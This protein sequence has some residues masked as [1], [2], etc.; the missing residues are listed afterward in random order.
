M[1]ICVSSLMSGQ[2]KLLDSL[3]LN[4]PFN[5]GVKETSKLL[6]SNRN[7]KLLGVDSTLDLL[8]RIE[9]AAYEVEKY[10]MATRAIGH[11]YQKNTLSLFLDSVN[12]DSCPKWESTLVFK[13]DS[14]MARRFGY[15]DLLEKIKKS[16]NGIR[17]EELNANDEFYG[18]IFYLNGSKFHGV[19]TIAAGRSDE[20]K[21]VYVSYR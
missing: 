12:C 2:E 3:F 10:P 20:D 11:T 8:D 18:K 4:I 15:L 9:F 16:G 17:E 19:L 5:L 21:S 7:F 6:E 13:Y 14:K 1:L